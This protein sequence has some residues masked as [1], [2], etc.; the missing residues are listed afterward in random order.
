MCDVI[1]TTSHS[2]EQRE[3]EEKGEEEEETGDLRRRATTFGCLSPFRN[4]QKAQK[5]VWMWRQ[6]LS[7]SLADTTLKD[8][9]GGGGGRKGGW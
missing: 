9:R 8:G 5:E 6:L 4:F 7:L 1:F 2:E 3:E